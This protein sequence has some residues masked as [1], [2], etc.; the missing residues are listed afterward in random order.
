MAAHLPYQED[1]RTWPLMY[2]NTL[3]ETERKIRK[4]TQ[5]YAHPVSNPLFIHS[6]MQE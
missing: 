1:T 2:R 5:K 3:N 4:K 6:F